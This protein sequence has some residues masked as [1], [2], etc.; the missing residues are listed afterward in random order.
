MDVQIPRAYIVIARHNPVDPSSIQLVLQVCLFSM[1]ID[2]PLEAE[3]RK[4]GGM[5]GRT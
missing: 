3:I 2:E 1:H 4:R 5:G